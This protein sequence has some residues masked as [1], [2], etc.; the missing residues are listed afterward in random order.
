MSSVHTQ[1]GQVSKLW[2]SA[3]RRRCRPHA[4]LRARLTAHAAGGTLV[5]MRALP[6][7]GAPCAVG[8]P[9]RPGRTILGSWLAAL[10]A[11]AAFTPVAAEGEP[12]PPQAS[13]CG[14]SCDQKASNCIDRCEESLKDDKA[15]VQ[16]KLTCVAA[17]EKCESACH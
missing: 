14:E 3:D 10:L 2:Q 9:Q 1:A 11:V 6:S 16:C 4:R 5:D 8:R 12:R 7:S 17:R 13:P 15:R